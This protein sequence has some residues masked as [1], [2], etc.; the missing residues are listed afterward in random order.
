[1]C[2]STSIITNNGLN[3]TSGTTLDQKLVWNKV[4]LSGQR[5]TF[6]LD[7]GKDSTYKYSDEPIQSSEFIHFLTISLPLAFVQM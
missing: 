6:L 7:D 5:V 3:F 1:M 4:P 2:S